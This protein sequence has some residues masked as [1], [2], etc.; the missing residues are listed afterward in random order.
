M[1]LNP[2]YMI[3]PSLEQYYVD[4]DTGLPLAKGVVTFYK[5]QARTVLKPI[6]TISGS[7]PNYTYV[8][9]P[10]PVSLS[11]TG[12][13]QDANGNNVTPITCLMTNQGI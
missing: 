13:F 1:P 5:D 11:A 2:S 7:P 6:Y 10:N 8:Q 3:A 4:K 12:T 9:L